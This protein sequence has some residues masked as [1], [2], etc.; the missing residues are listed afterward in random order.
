MELTVKYFAIGTFLT[1]PG[2]APEECRTGQA[3]EIVRHRVEITRFGIK[4]K[5]DIQAVD[6]EAEDLDEAPVSVDLDM[7]DFVV[8]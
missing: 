6:D 7:W 3:Y 2:K 5:T 8:E 1:F 4:A